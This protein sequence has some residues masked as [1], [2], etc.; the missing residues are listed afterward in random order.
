MIR[1]GGAAAVAI[2]L[3]V[4]AGAARAAFDVPG[5]APGPLRVALLL[6]V[7]DDLL[8]GRLQAEL[9]TIGLEVSRAVL[10]PDAPIEAQVHAA[11]AGGARAVI[12]ADGHRTEVWI[13]E[14]GSDRVG[15]RQELEVDETS[16][17]QAVL[18]TRTVEFLRISLGLIA[19]PPEPLPRPPATVRA[20]PPAPAAPGRW[21]TVDLTAGAL[22][23]GGGGG[24]TA[25]GG[26]ALRAQLAGM[27]GG[28]LCVYAPLSQA[29]LTESVAGA[30]LQS[31]TSVWMAGGGVLLAPR[32][33][34]RLSV[35]IGVGALATVIQTSG[36]ANP[37]AA[38]YPANTDVQVRA[39]FYGRGA[40][41]LRLVP[42][43]SLRIDVI[44][45]AVVSPPHFVIGQSDVAVWG[46]AF[47]AGLGG[48]ELRF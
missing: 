9:G 47:A 27:I 38:T 20:A 14:A 25:M 39:A 33:D 2:A 8:G 34:R 23:A 42:H 22:V 7:P 18:A 21:A 32:P 40:A 46:P 6:R 30:Q 37:S 29:L 3:L 10:S 13:A 41:R 45:G 26:L 5:V 1:G 12:V 43:L 48:A 11:L 16:G 31:R 44:G 4:W 35:E 19:A 17:Q 15:L 36:V 24:T 28:E